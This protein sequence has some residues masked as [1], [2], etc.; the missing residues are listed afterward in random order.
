MI[1]RVNPPLQPLDKK[2]LE[3][4]AAG[5]AGGL[6]YGEWQLTAA[7]SP[8]VFKQARHRLVRSGIVELRDRHYAVVKHPSE[9][10]LAIWYALTS[11]R[12]QRSLLEALAN[13]ALTDWPTAKEEVL[14]LLK[15]VDGLSGERNDAEHTAFLFSTAEDTSIVLVPA[16]E[17]SPGRTERL[18]GRKLSEQFAKTT[19]DLITLFRYADAITDQLLP[20]EAER[21]AW[22]ERPQL[23]RS[24]QSRNRKGSDRQ[25]AAKQ[26][27][28]RLRPSQE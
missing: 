19:D 20:A 2:V 10:P 21:P 12:Q 1:L 26:S 4:L 9:M 18:K 15:Q 16:V 8:S 13:V 7:V 11:D 24:D 23:R 6:S 5:K 28:P 25:S 3:K 17:N 27:E 22:P 14:W